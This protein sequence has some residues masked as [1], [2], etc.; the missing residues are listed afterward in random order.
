MDKR[1]LSII[2]ILIIV[3]G[4]I[5]IIS[6]HSSNKNGGSDNSGQPTSH[7]E[8]QGAKGVT[9]IEYGDYECPICGEFYQPMKQVFADNSANIYFQFRNLPLV[10]LHKNAFAA[11]RAA[12]AAGLQNKYWQMHDKL[13]TNQSEWSG[14]ND[15]LSFFQTYAGEIGLN[16]SQFNSDYSSGKV[17]SAIN[18]D[19]AAFAKTGQEQA[20]PTF[21][22]DGKVL[23]NTD[24]IDTQTGTISVDK[25]NQTIAQEIKAKEQTK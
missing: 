3:F 20:T 16:A 4:G 24:F 12:E 7:I 10:S 6:Q 5:F 21:F 17:N 19:L 18:A 25:F 8:G 22:L 1:F 13:Y 11:A 9:L 23:N 2:G 14:A 15:P